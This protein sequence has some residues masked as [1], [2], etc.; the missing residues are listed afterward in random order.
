MLNCEDESGAGACRGGGVVECWAVENT[1]SGI[2]RHIKEEYYSWGEGY[3]LAEP[4]TVRQT[5][6]STCT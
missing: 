5:E 2:L 6:C 3:I 4:L 1:K